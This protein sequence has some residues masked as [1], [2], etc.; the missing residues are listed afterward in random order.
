MFHVKQR[1]P[2]ERSI[3]AGEGQRAKGRKAL[4]ADDCNALLGV[5]TCDVSVVMAGNMSHW[6]LSR[7]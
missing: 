7:E 1:L 3:L 5:T 6:A 4:R 2:A